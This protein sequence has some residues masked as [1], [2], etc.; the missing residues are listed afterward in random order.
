MGTADDERHGC[1][2]LV[3]RGGMEDRGV[4]DGIFNLGIINKISF[5]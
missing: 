3:A 4:A 1:Y 2:L 5:F